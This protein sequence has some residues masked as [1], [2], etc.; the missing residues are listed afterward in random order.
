MPLCLALQGFP[1]TQSALGAFRLASRSY[2][3][4][5][6]GVERG[7]HRQ[8]LTRPNS[9]AYHPA[10]H[11]AP[12]AFTAHDSTLVLPSALFSMVTR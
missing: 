12:I 3:P 11:S 6:S 8:P 9:L 10:K 5:N 1:A 2:A 7:Q 4:A